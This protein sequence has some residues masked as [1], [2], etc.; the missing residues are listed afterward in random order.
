[1]ADIDLKDTAAEHCEIT[2]ILQS[3]FRD[4]LHELDRQ[5]NNR[6]DH[7]TT[8]HCE[9]S[10]ANSNNKM[11]DKHST[12]VAQLKLE[13]DAFTKV[14]QHDPIRNLENDM[15]MNTPAQERKPPIYT[16]KNS[17]QDNMGNNED[18]DMGTRISTYAA[19]RNEQMARRPTKNCRRWLYKL[20]S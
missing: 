5:A 4:A 13:A 3:A 10:S 14:D 7:C 12:P 11:K 16:D 6:T 20:K 1:M 15:A 19:H 9:A 18:K 2:K 8:I 17:D